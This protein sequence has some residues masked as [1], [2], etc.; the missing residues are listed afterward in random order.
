[1][2]REDIEQIAVVQAENAQ[3]F[4]RQFNEMMARLSDCKPQVQFNFNQG[5]CAYITYILELKIPDCVA[6]EYHAKGIMF[7]CR[8]CPLHELVTDGR[9]RRVQCKYADLGFTHLNNE[10]CEV[11]YRRLNLKEL[12]PI[13]DPQEYGK[14]KYFRNER[15]ERRDDGERR[16]VRVVRR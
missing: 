8:Q 2:I 12:E 15:T 16:S 14:K 3:D 10:C 6:D 13:G 5:H 4:Q 7:T 11:F 1:M 9:V